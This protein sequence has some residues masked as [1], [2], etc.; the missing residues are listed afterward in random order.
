MVPV[1]I[2]GRTR[3]LDIGYA[4]AEPRYLQARDA[5]KIPFLVGFDLAAVQQ[6]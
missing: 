6:S 1:A 3:V 5:L 4:N 2:S